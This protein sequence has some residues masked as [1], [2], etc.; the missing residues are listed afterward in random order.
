M[1]RGTQVTTSPIKKSSMNGK[2]KN[3]DNIIQQ[4]NYTNPYF[5]SVGKQLER[6]KNQ[7]N[8]ITPEKNIN[9]E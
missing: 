3:L 1:Q 5:K 7:I 6:I 4:N 9:K 8:P 2:L